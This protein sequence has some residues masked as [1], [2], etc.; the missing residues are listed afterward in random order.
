M[1]DE[2][3][4]TQPEAHQVPHFTPDVQPVDEFGGNDGRWKAPSWQQ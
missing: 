3:V 1:A 4:T 2:R